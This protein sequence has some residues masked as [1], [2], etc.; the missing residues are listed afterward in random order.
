M[1]SSAALFLKDAIEAT[2]GYE[3][4]IKKKETK[5]PQAPRKKI[6]E[7]TARH[8]PRNSAALPSRRPMSRPV[9]SNK[10]DA[11]NSKGTN[12]L[13]PPSVFDGDERFR[14]LKLS[15]EQS[16]SSSLST[17]GSVDD[18]DSYDSSGVEDGDD[19]A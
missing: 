16:S 7:R 19:A 2:T 11:R 3:I 12:A 1:W 8:A 5:P 17:I 6:D 9:Y 15:A 13:A 4:E 18:V 10:P 14:K